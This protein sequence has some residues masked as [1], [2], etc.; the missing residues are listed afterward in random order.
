MVA[1]SSDAD[2]GAAGDVP[3]GM[4]DAPL[5]ELEGED[6]VLPVGVDDYLSVA[7]DVDDTPLVEPEE[8]DG[9]FASVTE[10]SGRYRDRAKAE[11]YRRACKD[12]HYDK[13]RLW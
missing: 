2:A 7:V 13:N 5:V 4:D 12:R 9:L 10:T 3:A 1:V 8:E 11:N 6:G